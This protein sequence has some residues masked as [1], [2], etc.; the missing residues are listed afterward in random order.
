MRTRLIQA[1]ALLGAAAV[2]ALA[3]N[4]AALAANGKGFLLGKANKASKVTTLQRTKPGPALSLKTKSGPPLAVGNSMK[5][6]RLNADQVDG[7]SATDFAPSSVVGT[8]KSLGLDVVAL[9][10][11]VE[12]A[13]A[14]APIAAGFIYADG[15]LGK[16]RGIAG[17]S[18][19][20]GY[21][22]VEITGENYY[23]TNYAPTVTAECDGVTANANSAGGKLFVAFLDVATGAP[24]Q[25]AFAV[26]VIKL[27][28]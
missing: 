23:Y 10:D 7:K 18:Y 20:G 22:L 17:A 4:S 19:S 24:K 9:N 15:T 27:P 26:S 28:S 25:C 11:R 5:V 3:A 6:D 2:L 16:S 13:D 8:V 21:Y 14:L 12:T 1:L